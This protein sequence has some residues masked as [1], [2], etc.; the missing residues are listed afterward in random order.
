M[1]SCHYSDTDLSFVY[2]PFINKYIINNKNKVV[3]RSRARSVFKCFGIVTK[4]G[5]GDY[6]SCSKKL[7]C[8]KSD[9]S[10]QDVVP[11]DT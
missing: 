3:K 7:I 1:I 9:L 6:L 10:L 4:V 5:D 2:Q 11:G 8:S